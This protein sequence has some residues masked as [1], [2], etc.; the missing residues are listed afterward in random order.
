M[1]RPRGILPK[2]AKLGQVRLDLGRLRR[3]ATKYAPSKLS[4]DHQRQEYVPEALSTCEYVFVRHDA[5]QPPLSPP[6][7]GPFRVLQRREKAFQL[8]L[9]NRVDWVSIDRLEPS[10]IDATDHDDAV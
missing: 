1:N 2:L 3:I 6:Y 5:A 4:R 8:Q 9:G 10:Y 7:R